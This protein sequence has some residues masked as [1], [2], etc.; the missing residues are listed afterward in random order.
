MMAV[1]QRIDVLGPGDTPAILDVFC[2]AFADY[3]VMRYVLGPDGNTPSR[4]RQLI[5]YF[6]LRRV[7]LGGPLFGARMGDG[8]LAGVATMTV[9]IES[10]APPDLLAARD[11]VFDALGQECRARHDAYARAA[12]LFGSIGPHHHLNMLGVR[13][14][15]H[16]KGVG[17]LLLNAVA[18]L[19]TADARSSGV[20]LTTETS[21]N[22]KLYEHC[23]YEVVG[24]AR[25]ADSFQTW[26]LFR[27]SGINR[28]PT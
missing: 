2:D 4:L 12:T 17:R 8:T 16:G 15:W 27:P 28:F 5:G 1:D 14:A 13:H 11:R 10:V 3:P 25:V 23:G 19:A 6:V 7:R 18:D 24:E 21:E 26:G 20:S 9:P 22:V